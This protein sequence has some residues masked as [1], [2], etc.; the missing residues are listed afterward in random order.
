MLLPLCPFIDV[1]ILDAICEVADESMPVDRDDGCAVF[2]VELEVDGISIDFV[3]SH[4]VDIDD[5][6]DVFDTLEVLC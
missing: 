3:T 1:V 6:D 5:G 4:V 2:A